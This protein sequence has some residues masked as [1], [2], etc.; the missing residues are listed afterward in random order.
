VKKRRQNSQSIIR[1]FTSINV[2][3]EL[4]PRDVGLATN[5]LRCDQREKVDCFRTGA[6]MLDDINT[7]RSIRFSVSLKEIIARCVSSKFVSLITSSSYKSLKSTTESAGRRTIERDR[8]C[9]RA[10]AQ[11]SPLIT[12][13]RIRVALSDDKIKLEHGIDRHDP[14]ASLSALDKDINKIP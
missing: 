12:C 7:A 13:F 14:V 10:R 2:E 9:A 6:F 3:L 11:V 4:T 5:L 8:I 1:V